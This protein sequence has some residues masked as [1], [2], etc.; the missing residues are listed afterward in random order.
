[1]PRVLNAYSALLHLMLSV[2]VSKST[3]LVTSKQNGWCLRRMWECG[4]LQG[5]S[6]PTDP[7]LD[8]W[9][10]AVTALITPSEV[11]LGSLDLSLT[12]SGSIC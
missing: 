8:M 4:P 3:C 9:A 10:G 2:F 11:S 1:M 5:L 12:I 6:V 7:S